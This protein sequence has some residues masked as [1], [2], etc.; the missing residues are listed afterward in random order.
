MSHGICGQ[1][2]HSKNP[3]QT[4]STQGHEVPFR[5]DVSFE[6]FLSQPTQLCNWIHGPHH[7]LSEPN[8]RN[9]RTDYSSMAN[10]SI[11]GF[12]EYEIRRTLNML[13]QN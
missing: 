5:V 13:T 2:L 6:R 11:K 8:P 1:R 9:P 3:N 10:K 4:T 12:K 7:N